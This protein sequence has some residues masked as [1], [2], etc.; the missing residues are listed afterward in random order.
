MPARRHF[1]GIVQLSL[2]MAPDLK[3]AR[4]IAAVL[5]DG[6]LAACVSIQK[7][8]ES[9]YRW[10]GKTETAVETFVLI[11]AAKKNFLKIEKAI[12]KNQPYEVPEI[13][14]VPVVKG[15]QKYL[16]WLKG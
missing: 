12:L 11:K 3:T 7:G 8:W 9:R 4:K 5:V 15:H 6:K 16:E 14:A 10:K 1:D 13:V 2:C